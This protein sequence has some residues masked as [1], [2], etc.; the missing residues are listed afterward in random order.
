MSF[1]VETMGR[2][3]GCAYTIAAV[4]SLLEYPL[5]VWTKSYAGGDYLYANVLVVLLGAVPMYCV[6]SYGKMAKADRRD[7]RYETTKSLLSDA[8]SAYEFNSTTYGSTA[9]TETAN[10]RM[11]EQ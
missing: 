8:E 5:A 3:L 1:G 11:G 7:Y 2:V 9:G 10:Q 6:Y 4:F